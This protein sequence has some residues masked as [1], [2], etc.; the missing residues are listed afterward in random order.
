MFTPEKM[1]QI[2]AVF[3]RR[4]LGAVAETVIRD[5]NLHLTDAADLEPWAQE[6]QT[7]G[8]AGEEGQAGRDRRERI[9]S[10]LKD[11]SIVQKFDG[12][13]PAP[14]PWEALDPEIAETE[15]RL[16]SLKTERDANQKDLSRLEGLK[17]RLGDIPTLGFAIEGRDA[18]SYLCVETGRVNDKNLDILNAKLAPVLH[19]VLPLGSARGK[20]TVL[21]VSL[22][23]DKAV[24]D[25][26]LA[27]AGF[28]AIE[29]G[30]GEYALT[31]DEIRGIDAKI[32][33]LRDAVQKTNSQILE[34]AAARGK[35]LLSAL[36]KLRKERLTHRIQQ[37][38]RK[39]DHT[40]L[41]SGWVPEAHQ[42]GFVGAIREA[43]GDRCV[44]KRIRPEDFASVREGKVQV[45]VRLKNPALVKP[46]ELLTSAYGTPAY[47]SLDPTPLVGLSFLLMFGV[48]FGDVGHG[49]VLALIGGLLLL[50]LKGD[51]RQAGLLILYA[52]CS[53]MVFGFLFGS[54]FGYEETLPTL[55]LKPM[56]SISQLFKTLIFFGTGMVTVSCL[57]NVGNKL[58]KGQWPVAIFNKAGIVGLM[59]YWSGI[60]LAMQVLSPPATKSGFQKALPFLLG[61]AFVLLLLQEPISRFLMG[62]KK[63]FHEGAV[64]GMMEAVMEMLE[65]FLGFLANTVSFIRVA[66]FGLAHA[67]LFMAVF[68]LCKGMQ[69][70]ANGSLSIVLMIVGNIGIIMLEG[71]VVT[72]QSVRLEF[73]E[74][75]TRF[76]EHGNNPYR[77]V[78]TELQA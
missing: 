62:K 58:K 60:F 24:L 35:W 76:F 52:G 32:G 6:L 29:W 44:V 38:F 31:P 30:K 75:F 12:L 71:L 72:I 67:G 4:D 46:F 40:F 49:L 8:G 78:K 18:Y 68:E 45:P 73:Y 64:T 2:Q 17:S 39:T 53:S 59:F 26:A 48:M 55:W 5:G 74:F 56:E 28:E 20:T 57:M 19:M 33:T 14:E 11:L 9:E 23:R 3:H 66:A 63:L 22:K 13:E 34:I 25:A 27:E 70:V 43:T 21:A 61:A 1:T 54:I 51:A 15:G 36:F 41:L 42:S 16:E 47:T 77:P 69:N 10:M 65:T 7:Y 50:K 37:T